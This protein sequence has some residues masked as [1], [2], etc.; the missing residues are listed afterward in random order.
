MRD[1]AVLAALPQIILGQAGGL[2]GLSNLLEWDRGH[3]L[4]SF[5]F[6]NQHFIISFALF[7]DMLTILHSPYFVNPIF[8]IFANIPLSPILYLRL[9]NPRAI[10]GSTKN[11]E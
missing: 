8:N 4:L 3:L 7:C 5:D 11:W 1:R 6:A 9:C 2:A 10:I